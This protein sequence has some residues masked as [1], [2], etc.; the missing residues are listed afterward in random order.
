M[1]WI[2]LAGLLPLLAPLSALAQGHDYPGLGHIQNYKIN[3]YSERRF[4]AVTYEA[5]EGQ[6]IPVSGHTIYV[7]YAA[8]DSISHASNLEIYMS[9]E[10]VLKSL[11]A[12]VLWS[13]A[14]MHL[15]NEH[16]LAR[17][18][19]NGD[20]VYVNVKSHAEGGWYE[21]FITEQKT[22]EPSIVTTP[23]K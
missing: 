20:P 3:N 19:R 14:D 5:G 18:F 9:Y 17:F 21:L 1:R 15:E 8:E 11:K 23:G 7:E 4:D 13:P 22:F 16:M 6:K 10:A 2:C 12:E